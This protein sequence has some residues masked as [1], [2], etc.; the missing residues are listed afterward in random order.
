MLIYNVRI[1]NRGRETA[2]WVE[3]TGEFITAVGEGDSYGSLD[4]REDI[5]D[6][7]GAWLLPG[8]IDT[9]VHFREPGLTRKGCIASES[10]AA[11]AGGVTSYLEMPNT[12]PPATTIERVREK[13]A[14]AS[15]CS[16]ANYAFFIGATNDNLDEIMKADLSEIPGVKLFMGSSTGN[17]LV[18]SEST[19]DRLF[20]TFAGV[21]AVH[22]EDEATIARCRAAI[23]EQWGEEPPVWL[24]SAMRSPEACEK[25]TARAVELARRHDTRLHVLHI[26][27]RAELQYFSAGPVEGKRITAETCPHYLVFDEESLKEVP[28]GRLRKCNP[29]IKSADDRQALVAAVADGVIDTIATDHAPHCREDKEGSLF[30]AASGMPGIKMMLP[31][32]MDMAADPANAITRERVV[33]C[34]CHNPAL[35]YGIDRRGFVAPGYYADL[36]LIEATQPHA[37]GHDDSLSHLEPGMA[38]GPDWTPYAGIVTGHRV[39]LTIVNGRVAYDGHRVVPGTIARALRFNPRSSHPGS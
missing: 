4:G 21:I 9:H 6:G 32:M 7:R 38:A 8:A 15:G 22:A 12:A 26:S 20:A 31:L 33:E 2:G 23:R 16:M 30:K 19:I 39:A 29:A 3:T 34:C 10:A 5:V 11:V 14:I 28:D 13:M 27:T 37:I 1:I 35:L 36:T 17:M 25:A 24:H 18:D